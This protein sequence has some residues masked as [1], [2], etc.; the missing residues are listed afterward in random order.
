MEKIDY[1]YEKYPELLRRER[2]ILSNYG[3]SFTLI[4]NSIEFSG[5]SRIFENYPIRIIYPY[6]YPAFPPTVICDVD[7]ELLL[8]RHQTKSTKTLCLFGFSSERWRAHFSALEVLEEVEELLFKFSPLNYTE[9]ANGEDLVP[10]PLVNQFAYEAGKILIP[11]PFGTFTI[12]DISNRIE[13]ELIY[14]SKSRRGMLSKI[15]V[16][17]KYIKVDESYES[18]FRGSPIQK[19]II[20]KLN[21]VPPFKVDNIF[22]WLKDEGISIKRNKNHILL[23]VFEDEWGK[24]GNKRIG[25]VALKILNDKPMWVRCY[26]INSDDIAVRLPHSEQLKEKVITIIGCGSLGS[27]VTTSLAQEGITTLNLIDYD[28]IEPA[29]SIRHQVGQMWFGYPKVSS[30]KQRVM[31]LMPNTKVNDYYF[32]VGSG[33]SE[34]NYRQ[35]L[36]II[37]DSDIL[38]DTTASHK[39]SNFIN[40]LCIE[41]NKSLIIGS[42]TNGAWS[43]EI[44]IIIP[45]I[46]GCWNC[47][48]RNYGDKIPP[49]APKAKYQFAP[50]CDQPTFVGGISSINI[51]GGLIAQATIDTLLDIN[52][53]KFHYIIWSERDNAG[54]RNYTINYL[55]NPVLKDCEVCNGH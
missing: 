33:T 55:S 7:E 34:N 9:E 15:T 31:S 27:I 13:S 16:S 22:N 41:E 5:H 17:R 26:T 23:F 44:V 3:F 19:T 24:R 51:A 30:L 1:W 12:D 20:Y 21:K 50:G 32:S 4:D 2:E 47:W 36:E 42:V 49:S 54:N 8:V 38:I 53:E 28:V 18:F 6:G 14:D 45:T 43:C 35:L 40:K 25:W 48:G 46:S 10:E 29:N 11:L 52:D 39:V 37:K